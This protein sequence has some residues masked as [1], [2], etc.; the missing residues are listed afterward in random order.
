MGNPNLHGPP[1]RSEEQRF[2]D[3]VLV[4]LETCWLW[5]G[6]LKPHGYGFFAIKRDGKWKKVHAHRYAYELW[7][8][9]IPDGFEVDHL[10]RVRSCVNPDHL[11]ALS[12]QANR[13]RRDEL[14]NLCPHEEFR[15]VKARWGGVREL[16]V[17]CGRLLSYSAVAAEIP[18]RR[19]IRIRNRA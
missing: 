2:L 15:Q 18:G 14:V 11:E 4:D 6:G 13:R 19:P 3:M 12:L 1:G 16:C 10:C 7:V 17:T 9:P 8:E 5:E